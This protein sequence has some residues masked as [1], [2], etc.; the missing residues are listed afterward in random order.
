MKLEFLEKEQLRTDLPAFRIGD[1]LAVHLKIIEGDRERIQ[2]FQGTLIGR[3]GR[4]VKE[5][6]VLRRI[7]FGEGVERTF[8]LHS[9][10]IARIEVTRKGKV[11]RAKLYYLRSRSG[12]KAKV[13]ERVG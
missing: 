8:Y 5:T 6:I 7:S 11:R 13:K 12:K 3:K 10:R 4:D 1:T 9:P 2:V